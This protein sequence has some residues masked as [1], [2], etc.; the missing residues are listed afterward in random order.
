MRISLAV[1]AILSS[2]ALA[3]DE[4]E[5]PRSRGFQQVSIRLADRD[6]DDVST[7]FEGAAL[8]IGRRFGAYTVYGEGQLG[9]QHHEQLDGLAAGAAVHARRGICQFSISE[10][11][12]ELG[13]PCWI[14]VGVGWSTLFTRDATVSRPVL[15]IGLGGGMEAAFRRRRGGLQISL[16]VEISPVTPAARSLA[17]DMVAERSVSPPERRRVDAGVRFDISFLFGSR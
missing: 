9:Y 7:S 10:N 12:E 5:A 6:L 17:L 15:A 3:D 14:D 16:A 4:V 13:I 2:P 1:L 8:A 11:R